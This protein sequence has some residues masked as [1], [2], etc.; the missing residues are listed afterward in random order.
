M[1]INNQMYCEYKDINRAEV[2]SLPFLSPAVKSLYK[3]EVK[4]KEK[5]KQDFMS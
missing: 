1:I 5:K 3:K 4:K 2:L